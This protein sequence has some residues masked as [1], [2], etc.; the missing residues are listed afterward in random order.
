[1]DNIRFPAVW[2]DATMSQEEK[3]EF[4]K[5]LLNTRLLTDKLQN[6]LLRY[7]ETVENKEL[8]ESFYEDNNLVAR[9]AFNNGKLA[10]YEEILNLFKFN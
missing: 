7:K 10:A 2:F 9:I 5:Y 3:D 1:M 8:K 6:I 4:K